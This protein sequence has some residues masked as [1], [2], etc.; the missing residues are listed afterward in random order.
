MNGFRCV[1]QVGQLPIFKLLD[2]KEE[3]SFFPRKNQFILQ[4]IVYGLINFLNTHNIDSNI[5][6]AHFNIICIPFKN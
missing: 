3:E 1:T 6:N 4:I 2:E 5:E